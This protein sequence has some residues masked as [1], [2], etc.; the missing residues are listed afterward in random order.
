LCR[1]IEDFFGKL[2]DYRRIAM[3][4]CETEENFTAF[5]FLAASSNHKMMNVNMT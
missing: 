2:K 1:L 4:Y 5:T 3:R